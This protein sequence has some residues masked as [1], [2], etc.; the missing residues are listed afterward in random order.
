[1]RDKDNGK[2][3]FYLEQIL[4]SV[5]DIKTTDVTTKRQIRLVESY[6]A[7]IQRLMK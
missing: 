1:M 5:N 4:L 3:A 2:I 6:V 7:E